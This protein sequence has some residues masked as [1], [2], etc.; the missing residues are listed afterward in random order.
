MA[1]ENDLNTEELGDY[2]SIQSTFQ[3]YKITPSFNISLSVLYPQIIPIMMEEKMLSFIFSTWCIN[4]L[5]ININH[6]Q[7]PCNTKG[8]R[9]RIN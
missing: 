2:I 8:N 1:Q 5:P 9:L 3:K 6:T 7:T 4:F